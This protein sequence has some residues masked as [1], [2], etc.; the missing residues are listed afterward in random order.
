VKRAF[1]LTHSTDFYRARNKGNSYSHPFFV[2]NAVANSLSVSRF[3]ISTSHYIGNAV[4]RNRVKRRLKA[5]LDLVFPRFIMG[6]DVVIISRKKILDADFTEIRLALEIIL[7]KAS[8][9]RRMDS[10]DEFSKRIS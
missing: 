9:L 1:R 6:W 10:E 2:I 3:G 8:V 4:Q 5:C 7:E